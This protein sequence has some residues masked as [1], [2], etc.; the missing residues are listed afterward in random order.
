M[1][2]QTSSEKTGRNMLQSV[3][4]WEF[5][6]FGGGPFR[7]P[8]AE[9]QGFRPPTDFL[10]TS[11]Q[12]LIVPTS[13]PSTN[14]LFSL[15]SLCSHLLQSFLAFIC[16]LACPSI[17]YRSNPSNLDSASL[18]TLS[19]LPRFARLKS[20]MV[21]CA[22]LLTSCPLH[23]WGRRSHLLVATSQASGYVFENR[24]LTCKFNLHFIFCSLWCAVVT[25]C[26]PRK[27][28]WRLSSLN[29]CL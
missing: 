18:S 10:Q 6:S 20:M 27:A 25:L 28:D 8:L 22:V 9:Y 21:N 7:K 23:P 19:V 15:Q 3:D 4:Q 2:S 29:T 1:F 26:I 17:Y 11:D 12:R 5:R 13:R 24:E 16:I 14:L